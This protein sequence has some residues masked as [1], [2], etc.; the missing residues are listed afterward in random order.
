MH[1]GD[2]ELD[3][4]IPKWMVVYG[5]VSLAFSLVNIFKSIFCPNRKRR[6]GERVESSEEEQSPINRCANS[7]EGMFNLFLF[8]WLIVGSVW[9]LGK[10][11]DWDDAGR[12]NCDD[13]PFNENCCH[14]GMFLFA[15][16]FII[17]MWSLGFLIV[18]C[19]CSCACIIL[20][21]AGPAQQ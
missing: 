21:L 3:E 9:V 2:C 15:F 1:I 14:K 6:N 18:C 11:N 13:L 4:R 8:V 10:Y 16:I 19:A 12:P 5:S 17:T 20:A 7:I